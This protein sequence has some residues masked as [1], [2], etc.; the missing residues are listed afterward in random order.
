MKSHVDIIN[1]IRD[2]CIE[3]NKR[4][5]SDENIH[6]IINRSKTLVKEVD[7]VYRDIRSLSINDD[8]ILITI[9][10]IQK[11]NDFVKRIEGTSNT[12]S[13]FIGRSHYKSDNCYRWWNS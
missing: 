4:V 11:N 1:G 9:V 12:S 6:L 10:D 7:K 3:M 5:L 8:I 2:I 13:S